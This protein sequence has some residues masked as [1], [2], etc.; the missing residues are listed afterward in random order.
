MLCSRPAA[1]RC[2][3]PFRPMLRNAM[4][5]DAVL[6]RGTAG[7]GLV[8]WGNADVLLA[9]PV[10]LACA[11]ALQ[12][13]AGAAPIGLWIGGLLLQAIVKLLPLVDSR[14]FVYFW[15]DIDR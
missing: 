11:P 14:Q 8:G 4:L 2:A 5:F 1:L 15:C 3:A 12:T 10:A 13:A 9:S 6:W 7:H